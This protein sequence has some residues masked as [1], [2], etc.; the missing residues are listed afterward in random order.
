MIYIETNRFPQDEAIDFEK[1]KKV[2]HPTCTVRG[3]IL[4]SVLFKASS[5]LGLTWLSLINESIQIEL[6]KKMQVF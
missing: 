5:L 6:L 4:N 1:H 3:K 2:N